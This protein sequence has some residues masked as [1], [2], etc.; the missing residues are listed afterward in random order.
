MPLKD[1]SRPSR[2]PHIGA[3]SGPIIQD[4]DMGCEGEAAEEQQPRLNNT[5]LFEAEAAE[6]DAE[7]R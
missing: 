3:V 5:A 4:E 1:D 2:I 7:H 6:V